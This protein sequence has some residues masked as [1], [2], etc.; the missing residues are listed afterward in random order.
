[1][2]RHARTVVPQIPLH[3]T[4]RGNNRQVCFFSQADFP[5]YLDLLRVASKQSDCKIH[6]YALMTNHIHL[7]L[8]PNDEQ[9][10][11]KLMK[12]LGERYVSYVNRRY[13]RTGTLWEGRFNS[14]L[15]QSEIYLMI[16]QRYI[17]LNPVRAQLVD[18]PFRYPWSSYRHNAHGHA[19]M[20]LT[21]HELYLR[22]GDDAAT[23]ECAYRALFQDALGAG[24]L[25]QLRLSTRVGL[26][27]GTQAFAKEVARVRSG[28]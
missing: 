3:V 4:Q 11:A 26:P 2:P 17:E 10:P 13:A 21:H 1:M 20:L 15:V 16:C 9:G 28:V 27:L 8:T 5:V 14:C 25:E 18:D 7:L 22:L 19:S 23:R 24:T 12:F 6:A